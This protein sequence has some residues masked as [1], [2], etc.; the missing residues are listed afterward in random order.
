MTKHELTSADVV[1][2]VHRAW[3]PRATDAERVRRAIDVALAGG[4]GGD[5]ATSPQH[6]W[7]WTARVI[8]AGAIAAASGGAGYLAGHRAG[9]R[10]APTVAVAVQAARPAQVTSSSAPLF[11]PPVAGSQT[12]LGPPRPRQN[13]HAARREGDKNDLAGA[14]SLAVELRALRNI[15]RALRDG[16][17]GLALAFLG[18]L[19]REVPHG[20]LTEE[21][22]AA[23]TIARCARDDRPFDIDLAGE[24]AQRHPGSVY[25]RRVEQACSKTDSPSSGDSP[26]WRS[27]E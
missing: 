16:N 6:A 1:A 10:D 24:F 12:P 4:V 22:D 19:D 18:E 11:L 27:K 15:E 8:A 5:T 2:Q 25:K 17:P 14:E 7:S 3:S 26:S 9:L 13:S 23:T 20:Q 21:R